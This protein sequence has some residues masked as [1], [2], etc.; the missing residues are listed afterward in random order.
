MLDAD[1]KETLIENLIGQLAGLPSIGRKTAQRLAYHILAQDSS[2]VNEL[3]RTLTDAKSRIHACASCGNYTERE[4]CRICGNGRR[5]QN[6]ICVVEKPADIL[7]FERSG[8][9]LGVYHVLGG[10][11]SPL[12]GIG[13]GDLNFARLWERS[14]QSQVEL[15]LA[16]N[17]NAEGEATASYIV[18]KLQGMPVRI[19]RLARGIPVGSEL[20]YVDE[21]TV[22]RAL[23][24]R[25]EMG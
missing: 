19:S 21:L 14:R 1:I 22:Q 2:A 16:L 9:Y 7:A 13:P 25:V 6:M 20:E 12:D 5:Q 8:S 11:I 18:Q 24:S 23:E 3:A 4:T 10:T 17:T 15:I